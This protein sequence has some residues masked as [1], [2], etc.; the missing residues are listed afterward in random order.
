MLLQ[1]LIK[2]VQTNQLR[3]AAAA[4]IRSQMLATMKSNKELWAVRFVGTR[5]S[6]GL[7]AVISGDQHRCYFL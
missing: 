2:K 6:D 4:A 7:L 1:R 5:T 3:P